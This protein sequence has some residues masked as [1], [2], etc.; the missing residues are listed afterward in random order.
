MLKTKKLIY[1]ISL[2]TYSVL[3]KELLTTSL[4]PVKKEST[5]PIEEKSD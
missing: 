5:D 1:I 2:T 4:K 3:K